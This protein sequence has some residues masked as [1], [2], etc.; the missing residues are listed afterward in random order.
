MLPQILQFF[1]LLLISSAVNFYDTRGAYKIAIFSFA[2]EYF[3]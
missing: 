3:C 1:S 2:V